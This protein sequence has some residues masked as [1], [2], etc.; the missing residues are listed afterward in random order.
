MVS[1]MEN[2]DG[3]MDD[4]MGVALFQETSIYIYI[5]R[6]NKN[7]HAMFNTPLG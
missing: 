2:P 6:T 4:E 1:F 3:K 7:H 5:C